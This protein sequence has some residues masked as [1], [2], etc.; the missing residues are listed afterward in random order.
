MIRFRQAQS[1]GCQDDRSGQNAED[2]HQDHF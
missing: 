2:L 1:T